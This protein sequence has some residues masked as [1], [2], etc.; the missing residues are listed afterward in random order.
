M[1]IM[2]KIEI[3]ST[4]KAKLASWMVQ[5]G[6]VLECRT[7]KNEYVEMTWI[8]VNWKGNIYNIIDVDGMVCRIEKV[9]PELAK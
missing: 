8:Q 1:N 2:E 3:E 5:H 9:D 4:L 6:K 7:G